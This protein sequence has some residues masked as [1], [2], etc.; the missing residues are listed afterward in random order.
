M[1][2]TE[3]AYLQAHRNELIE[4]YGSKFLVIK[5]EA[6]SGAFDSMA[7]A[8]QGAATLHGLEN[9]LIRQATE[10]DQIVSAPA[11]TLGILSANL[12]HSISSTS[13]TT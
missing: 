6:V 9:V 12:S 11:L 1:L 10:P 13:P 7:E 8:L 5:G 3:I 2:E 4:Q